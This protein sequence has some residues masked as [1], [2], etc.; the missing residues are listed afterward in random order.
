MRGCS[1]A[2]P[3][4][5]FVFQGGEHGD[6][7]SSSNVR[8]WGFCRLDGVE[9]HSDQVPGL[10][11]EQREGDVGELFSLAQW[12]ILC[13]NKQRLMAMGEPKKLQDENNL[14]LE[15][16]RVLQTEIKD[17]GNKVWICASTDKL[18]QR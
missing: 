15:E 6:S 7:R 10:L 5:P 13:I 11:D 17:E 2:V 3:V 4:L 9:A 12:N 8:C 18:S 14:L 1:S 16:I